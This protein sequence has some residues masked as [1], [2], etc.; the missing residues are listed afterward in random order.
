VSDAVVI[1]CS[2]IM[3]VLLGAGTDAEK[4]FDGTRLHAPGVIDF[5]VASTLRRL[6]RMEAIAPNAARDVLDQW[7]TLDI[8]RHPAE[9]LLVRM[10][11][12]RH[13]FSAYDASYVALAEAMD[14]PLLTADKRMA[15][16]A[17][18]YCDVIG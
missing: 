5:E 6:V 1:D 11:D 9:Q 18:P 4:T 17:S 14:A 13:N 3:D 2:A 8:A 16:A 7:A 15:L 10:W 12:L